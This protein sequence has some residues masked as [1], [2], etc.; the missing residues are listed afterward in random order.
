M[1]RL[2]YLYHSK[3]RIHDPTPSFFKI[4]ITGW[5]LLTFEWDDA[6]Q[7]LQRRPARWQIKMQLYSSSCCWCRGVLLLNFLS[8]APH[9]SHSAFYIYL[10]SWIEGRRRNSKHNISDVTVFSQWF[11]LLKILN[12]FALKVQ[13]IKQTKLPEIF[14]KISLTENWQLWIDAEIYYCSITIWKFWPAFVLLLSKKRFPFKWYII[15]HEEL[16]P[17]I[18]ILNLVVETKLA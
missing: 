7:Q 3:S 11:L 16:L 18:R 5:A 1:G 14:S 2:T 9:V 8:S 15:N 12:E 6:S 4:S 10:I 13:L 17:L